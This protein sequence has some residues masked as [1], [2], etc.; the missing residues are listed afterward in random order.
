M[1][2]PIVTLTTDFGLSDHY[3]GA[4]KGVILG[5]CPRAQIVDIS[6]EVTPFEIAQGAYLL[7]QAYGCFPKRTVHIAVVDP[8]VGSARRAILVEAAGQ[9]FVGPDNGIFAMAM[10][11]ENH[12][13]RAISSARYF[14]HPVS[15][16]F[17][18]RDVFAPVAAHLAAG[19][20]A[21][22]MGKII[23][24]V[25][26]LEFAPGQGRGRVLHVDRFGNIVTSLRAADF[27]GQGLSLAIG[28]R[29]ISTL[30]RHYAECSP[31]RLF[32]IEGSAGYIEI[33]MNRGSAAGRIGCGVGAAVTVRR[34]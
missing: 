29:R 31:G 14:R 27:L 19:V 23:Q 22:R 6:H 8:G 12:K 26:H 33:S 11:R 7:A 1:A 17:H 25:V 4:M 34:G 30:V 21:A 18:G 5:I 13:V 16:T 28:R 32:L 24:D 9:Y 2:Q 20:S 10:A 3:V 15:R